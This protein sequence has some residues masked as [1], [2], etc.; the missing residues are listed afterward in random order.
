M[1]VKA[2]E[3]LEAKAEILA[4]LS[5][6]RHIMSGELLH[7][8]KDYAYSLLSDADW[9]NGQHVYL[10]DK[11]LPGD[12]LHFWTGKHRGKSFKIDRIS[13]S[14][15]SGS[16]LYIFEELFNPRKGDKFSIFRG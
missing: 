7:G 13:A 12:E 8:T 2:R 9:I 16:H 5:G 1:E 3:K 11:V 4:K 15:Y 14:V 10:W 6:T